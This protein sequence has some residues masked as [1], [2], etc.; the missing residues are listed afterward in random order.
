MLSVGVPTRITIGVA[1]DAHTGDDNCVM[2]YDDANAH[3]SKANPNAVYYTPPE[4]AGF[5]LCASGAGTGINGADW[6]PQPRYGDAAS[7]RGNCAGQV[8]VNDAVPAP[9]R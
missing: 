9:R 3:F 8:L 6:Q 4:G 2:R 1:N 7:G 5:G